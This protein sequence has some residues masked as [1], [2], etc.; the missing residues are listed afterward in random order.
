[1]TQPTHITIA[2]RESELAIWQAEYIKSELVSL[3]PRLEVTILGM[4]T[5]GDKTPPF[6]FVMMVRA[7]RCNL[8]PARALEIVRKGM[9]LYPGQL[10]LMAEKLALDDFSQ[11]MMPETTA[12]HKH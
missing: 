4:T 5:Q 3:Y 2:T 7:L 12:G 10:E 1:M 9:S 8:E 6:T 11:S